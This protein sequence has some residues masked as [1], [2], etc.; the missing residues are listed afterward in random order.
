[1]KDFTDTHIGKEMASFATG[2][3]QLSAH[4]RKRFSRVGA[5]LTD[6]VRLVGLALRLR[7]ADLLAVT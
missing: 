1:M 7:E 4:L 5:F 3:H 2:S 6:R